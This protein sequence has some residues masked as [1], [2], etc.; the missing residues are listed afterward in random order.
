LNYQFLFSN[1]QLNRFDKTNFFIISKTKISM[2][3]YSYKLI[4]A[5]K[6]KDFL[7][8]KLQS[9]HSGRVS[10]AT[11]DPILVEV[12]GTKLSVK[13]L[14]TITLPEPAQLLVTPFD[15]STLPAIE[16]AIKESNLGVNP[17]NNGAGLRLVFPPLTEETRKARLKEVKKLLEE[18]KIY[19][20][21]ERQE[22]LKS[23]KKDKDE[24]LLSEDEF[25]Q[26]EKS[27]QQEVD[28]LNQELE[29]IAKHKE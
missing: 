23:K 16:K 5:Q 17:I 22:L 14:A 24:G 7:S 13:E 8:H 27:L 10:P 3:S 28:S 4:P 18:A 26:F 29:L 6:I 21:Q 19:L 20:R 25:K 12:Y 15:R 2:S 9:I 1:S 11:L